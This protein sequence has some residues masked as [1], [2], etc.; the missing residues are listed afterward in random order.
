MVY[1][2]V[3]DIVLGLDGSHLLTTHAIP[4]F[5]D[6]GVGTDDVPAILVEHNALNRRVI[7]VIFDEYRLVASN[8]KHF[9]QAL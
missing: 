6:F 1:N 5:D 9:D 3:I 7:L 8:V 2:H 4:Y